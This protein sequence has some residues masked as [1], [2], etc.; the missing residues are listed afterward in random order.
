MQYAREFSVCHSCQI[1]LVNKRLN[2]VL[3][4]VY[5][6]I[7]SLCVNS[8]YVQSLVGIS[9]HA[10]ILD[11]VFFSYPVHVCLQVRLLLVMLLYCKLDELKV[12]ILL[13]LIIDSTLLLNSAMKLYCPSFTSAI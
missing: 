1:M 5:I 7:T 10:S 2:M 11:C 6:C 13:C 3:F 12:A 4:G 9:D 8:G